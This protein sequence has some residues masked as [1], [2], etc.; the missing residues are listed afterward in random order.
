MQQQN[1]KCS[2]SNLSSPQFKSF[3]DIF[4]LKVVAVAYGIIIEALRHIG[5]F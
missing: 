4:Y 1:L 2:V 5:H 3:I